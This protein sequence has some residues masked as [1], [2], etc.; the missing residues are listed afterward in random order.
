VRD[1]YSKVQ[2]YIFEWGLSPKTIQVEKRSSDKSPAAQE[3]PAWCRLYQLELEAAAEQ[4]R[5]LPEDE[6]PE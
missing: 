2:A 5:L 3:I 6:E 4:V 1:G